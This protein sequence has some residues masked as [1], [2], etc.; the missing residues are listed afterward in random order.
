MLLPI[1]QQPTPRN[2]YHF[3]ADVVIATT[4]TATATELVGVDRRLRSLRR[5]RR[6]RRH[7]SRF[8]SLCIRFFPCC[9]C[10]L[11]L[12]RC[13]VARTTLGELLLRCVSC[14]DCVHVFCANLPPTFAALNLA[15]WYDVV[16]F[17]AS[18]GNETVIYH[19]QR[20]TTTATTR[21]CADCKCCVRCGLAESKSPQL[22]A[23]GIVDNCDL[24]VRA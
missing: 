1:T 12:F 22:T 23:G 17:C 18:L 7:C 15:Q 14:A 5:V 19:E 13:L 8:P 6:R 11:S 2:N 21:R 24:L 16:A 4:T 9:C 3:V 20:T 10:K